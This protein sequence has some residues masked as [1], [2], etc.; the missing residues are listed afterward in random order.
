M[1]EGIIFDLGGVLA[2]DVWEHLLLDTQTGIAAIYNLDRERVRR[3]GKD[4]WKKYSLYCTGGRRGGKKI[5]REYWHRFNKEL[6]I[7]VPIE[8]Y[9]EI[10]DRFI[11]P[12]KGMRNILLELKNR[13]L[14]LAICSDN[15]EFW[16]EKQKIKLG[17]DKILSS[18]NF[19]LSSRV[20][21]SKSSRSFA[22]LRVAINSLG[23]NKESCLFIDDKARNIE[24]ALEYGIPSILFPSNSHRGASYLRAILT[25]MGI[26]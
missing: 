18:A 2:Y 13:G 15:T 1:I 10:T 7:S 6:M 12:I 4:L 9:R 26:I 25:R 11:K 5:E 8:D 16:F 17:L 20:G 3:A 23:I 14:K 22:M 21:V 19:V 24:R